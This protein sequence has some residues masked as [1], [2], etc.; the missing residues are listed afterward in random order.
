MEIFIQKLGTENR[1]RGSSA[2]RMQ[3][4]K[5]TQPRGIDEAVMQNVE[6]ESG[7]Q[8]AMEGQNIDQPNPA[9]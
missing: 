7:I 5:R 2:L 3:D 6:G 8:P 4:W 1:S 9:P